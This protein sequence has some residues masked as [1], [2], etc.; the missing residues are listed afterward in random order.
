ML[1]VTGPELFRQSEPHRQRV[2]AG[3]QVTFESQYQT[4]DQ[5]II[6]GLIHFVP[7]FDPHNKVIGF[8]IFGH[9]IT[10]RKQTEAKLQL[11]ESRLREA[12]A[13]SQLG[14]FHWD[15]NSNKVTWSDQLFRIYGHLP[16]QFEPD[17][18]SYLAAIHPEDRPRV[19]KILDDAIKNQSSVNHDYTI[20]LP[21]GSIRWLH[22]RVLVVKDSQGRLSGLEGTCQDITERKLSQLALQQ[23]D[24]RLQETRKL[25]SLGVLAGGIAHDFNNLLT[26]IL[27]NANLIGLEMPDHSS[28]QEY[29]EKINQTVERAAELCRQMLAYSGRGRFV[30][31]PIELGRF[32][33]E[34]FA[35]LHATISEKAQ[36]SLQLERNLPST[37]ADASQLHQVLVS[38]VLNASE[39]LPESGGVIRLSTSLLRADRAILDSTLGTPDLP[40]GSYLSLQVS[41]NGRGMSADIQPKIFEP[42]FTTKFTGRGLGL[43]AVLGIMRGHKGALKVHSV[44]GEGSTFTLLFPPSPTTL[45][46]RPETPTATLPQKAHG[47]IL[48]VDD[49][50]TLRRTVKRILERLGFDAVLA[51]DGKEAVALFA[52]DPDRFP[53]VLLDLTMPYMDGVETFHALERLRPGVRVVLMSG[54]NQQESLQRFPE[55]GPVSFLEK[56]FSLDALQRVLQK[57]L[58]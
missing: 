15:A 18:T 54:Y 45:P 31:Q 3:E 26:S 16:G 51:S 2:L 35:R 40:E 50:N 56:P 28:I 42:F 53:A 43:S 8:F 9:D 38:L 33:E 19:T 13:I 34:A 39:A 49:D 10:E 5:K 32:L 37:E 36:L 46:K 41:D 11:S 23:R 6:F 7:D 47:P 20:S 17:V 44:P 29:L 52:A 48:V 12:Q 57:T 22:A 27:G 25:E 55:K 1:E 21:D 24:Q 58:A 30:V 14:N 4:P